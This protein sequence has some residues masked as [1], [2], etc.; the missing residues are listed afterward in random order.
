MAAEGILQVILR[1]TC[2]TK[3]YCLAGGIL[4]TRSRLLRD[5][6]SKKVLF[7]NICC[8]QV[9]PYSFPHPSSIPDPTRPNSL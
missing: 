5:G 6:K 9:M 2:R 1:E 3:C 7:N 8:S 4:F